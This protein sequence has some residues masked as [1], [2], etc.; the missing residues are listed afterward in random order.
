MEIIKK[1]WKID[2]IKNTSNYFI[3]DLFTKSLA[4]IS[5]PIFTRLLTV[6]QYGEVNLFVSFLSVG[7][8]VLSLGFPSAISNKYLRE[9]EGFNYFLGTNLLSLFLF[10]GIM[11]FLLILFSSGISSF[12]QIDTNLLILAFISSGLMV[13]YQLYQYYLKASQKSKEYVV[14]G[15]VYSLLCTLLSITLVYWSGLDKGLARILGYATTILLVA[16]ISLKMLFSISKFEFKREHLYYALAFGIPFMPHLLS[17]FVLGTFD[18]V[19][20]NQLTG[21]A[22]TGLYSLAYNIGVL[23]NSIGIAMM[24]AVTPKIYKCIN[25][26]DYNGIKTKFRVVSKIN[27]IGALGVAIF[28]RE[29]LIIMAP[30]KFLDSA[31]IIPWVVIGNVFLFYYMFYAIYATYEKKT[32]FFSLI[33]IIVGGI[34]IGLNY[35]LIPIY[36][37]KI[38]AL[39]TVFSYVLLFLF[40]FLNARFF[41]RKKVVPLSIFIG[42]F[43]L[44]IF[45]ITLT[46]VFISELENL[47][48]KVGIKVILFLLASFWVLRKELANFKSTLSA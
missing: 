30:D 11:M 31:E 26:G 1:L 39:T 5:V 23:Q 7:T 4:L 28:A 37:Y 35:W 20:I 19:I 17:Q 2:L 3:G 43:I 24:A 38:A 34:N 42:D 16:I 27:I 25:E 29:I 48:L 14:I 47:M 13:F 6:E 36:G 41:L 44:L 10:Q 22:N 45:C 40:H 9:P 15:V 46:V 12:F 21:E 33:T 18:R 32:G 8:I